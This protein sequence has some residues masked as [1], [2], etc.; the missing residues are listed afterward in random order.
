[1]SRKKQ[2]EIGYRLVNT[3]GQPGS[4]DDEDDDEKEARQE[5]AVCPCP[6][7]ETGPSRN[8]KLSLAIWQLS[9]A[10]LKRA[11]PGGRITMRYVLVVNCNER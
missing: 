1:M 11:S 9:L 5:A 10:A 8:L 6:G 7:P 4:A 3:Q 2:S